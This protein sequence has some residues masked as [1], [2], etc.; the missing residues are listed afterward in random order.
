MK[1]GRMQWIPPEEIDVEKPADESET[2][3][4]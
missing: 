1:N 2:G 4:Q 3:S